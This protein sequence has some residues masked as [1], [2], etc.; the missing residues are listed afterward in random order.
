M[1][2]IIKYFT[3]LFMLLLLLSTTIILII[4][5]VET[6]QSIA[7]FIKSEEEK[8][9]IEAHYLENSVPTVDSILTR[10][11]LGK[12]NIIDSSNR[13]YSNIPCSL[14]HVIADEYAFDRRKKSGVIR[15]RE[16]I[17]VYA[18][19]DSTPQG[20]LQIIISYD[21]EIIK[22]L[23]NS[24]FLF[25]Y[26]LLII[27]SLVMAFIFARLKNKQLHIK[28]REDQYLAQLHEKNR[29]LEK[30]IIQQES[31]INSKNR[32]FSIIAH[33]LRN[34][35]QVVL[36]YTGLLLDNFDNMSIEE[37]KEYFMDIET[38]TGQL[39]RLL[40]NL[41]LWS[42]TQTNAVKMRPDKLDLHTLAENTLALVQ[43]NASKKDVTLES[44]ILPFTVAYA[45]K[46]MILTILRN[47]MTNAVK[48]TPGGGK[49]QLSA[50]PIEHNMIRVTVKDSGIGM[51][52]E[53]QKKL[54][55]TDTSFSHKGTAGEEG[56]GL[57]LVL[58]HEF[59]QQHRG[60]IWVESELDEGSEFHFTIPRHCEHSTEMN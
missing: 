14:S 1:S 21:K 35:F 11:S 45:D 17:A 4:F 54:F 29:E 59:V 58:C 30:S 40:D 52:E 41:L 13:C 46:D 60:K 55:R 34:P 23:N 32:F 18:T 24:R 50:I 20:P 48:F 6:T 2:P 57:G 42:R 33:D 25:Y 7:N 31:A 49:I 47:L 19:V 56:T 27:S 26:L 5:R 3:Q 44:H 9:R 8:L 28:S 39:M 22:S 16:G 37:V 15:N 10:H 38:A 51:S 12:V 53:N 36:G 43:V